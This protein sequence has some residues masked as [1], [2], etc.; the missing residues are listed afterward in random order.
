MLR[1][2]LALWGGVGFT[3]SCGIGHV[4]VA[5]FHRWLTHRLRVPRDLGARRTAPGLTGFLERLFFTLAVA[6]NASDALTAMMAWLALKLAANWQNRPDI[7][8]VETR[9]NYAF[10]AI[11]TGFL[12]MLF[13]YVGGLIIWHGHRMNSAMELTVDTALGITG[14]VLG[15]AA[16]AMALP[17]LLQMVYGRPRLEFDCQEFTGSDGKQLIIRIKNQVTNRVLRKLGV[18]RETGELLAYFDIHE[19]GTNRSV[20]K[21]VSAMLQCAPLGEAGILARS[22]PAFSVGL[23]VAHTKDQTT[24]IVDAKGEGNFQELGAG[25]YT[26][27]ATIICREQVHHV[28]KNFKVGDAP[29][30]TFWV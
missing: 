6:V 25:D 21:D 3:I 16:A 12:S 9:K 24:W 10:S 29:H 18:E 20:K 19:Q 8:D 4:V 28:R 14:V 7:T 27:L 1:T 2:G 15:L 30:L 5:K 11:V 23:V 22:L 26:A 17:P 13:A